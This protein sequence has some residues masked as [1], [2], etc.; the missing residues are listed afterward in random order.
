MKS[1]YKNL[2]LGLCVGSI[3]L[4]SCSEDEETRTKFSHSTPVIESASISPSS[5]V[6]GDSVT[7]TAKV[8]DKVTPLS[9]L[10]LKMI[11][12]DVLVAE[13]EIRTPGNSSEVSAKFKVDFKSQLPDNA[14]VEVQ[15]TLINVEGDETKGSI[16]GLK[17]N[18]TYYNKLYL[19]LDNGAVHTLTPKSDKSDNYFLE[20]VIIKSNNIKYRIAEKITAD[21]QID[22]SGYVWGYQGGSIQIVD[23]TGDYITT[24]NSLIDYITAFE[25]DDYYFDGRVSG[26]KIDPKY[27]NSDYFD[28]VTVEKEKFMKLTRTIAK[29]QVMTLFGD[30]ASTD[31]V[32]NM[33]YF[34]RISADQVKFVGAEGAYS[35]YY[36]PTRKT[37]IVDPDK[38][39]YPDV[40]LAAG[41]GLGYPSKIKS[42]THTTWSF[43]APL[44][45]IIF[46]KIAD[47]VYQGTVYL[48]ATP[49][50]ASF[51]FFENKDWGNEKKSTDFTM[52]AV[53][54]KDTDLGKSD[55]NWYAATGATSGNYKITINL[56][57]KV[58]TAESVT[59]P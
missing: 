14:N 29:D 5:F 39:S 46:R 38:R 31:V 55:G 58:A 13:T 17:G 51:K 18:R 35:L 33:D 27:L 36:S 19:V 12:N 6:Y 30:L 50:K 15:L 34:E 45:A 4:T 53:L 28:E 52:P 54:A 2:F 11:V 8:S 59:L 24:T 40:L 1:L 47:N 32:Y 37:M 3:F 10:S 48:D 9:T 41:E 57:T 26:E 49:D 25:F 43:N 56:S 23:E 21:N 16:D 42:E 22:F 44:Q 20:D 7:I